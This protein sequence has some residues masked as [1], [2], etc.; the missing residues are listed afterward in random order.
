MIKSSIRARLIFLCAVLLCLLVTSTAYLTRE[1]SNLLEIE[2]QQVELIA[3]VKTANETHRTF[4]DLKY[5]LSDHAVSLLMRSENAAHAANAA[6]DFELDKLEMYNPE[7]VSLVRAELDEVV[8]LSFQAIDAYADDERVLG[9]S[10]MAKA[11]VHISRVDQE[12]SGLVQQFD[13]RA[14]E[15]QMVIEAESNRVAVV[16]IIIVILGGAIGLAI[17][18]YIV[19]SIN[20]PLHSLVEAISAITHG[21]LNAGIPEPSDD[22]FGEMT[23]AL[24]LL[25]DGL[26]E[27]KRFD[28]ERAQSEA[29]LRESEERFEKAFN[30][31]PSMLAVISERSGEIIDVN[32]AWLTAL[33][34]DRTHMIG[35][36]AD[37]AE[38]WVDSDA[39]R[40]FAE[41][42]IRR[43]SIDRFEARW[44]TAGDTIGEFELSAETIELNGEPCAIV[45]AIDVTERNRVDRLKDEF[46]SMVSHELRTPLTSIKGSLDLLTAG[47]TG[48]HSDDSRRLIEI[49]K[50]NSDRLLLIV[51]DILDAQKIQS[52]TMDYLLQ[53]LDLL[54]ALKSS[55]AVNQALGNSNNT[56]FELIDGLP[57]VKVNADPQK[58][59]QVLANLLSNAAKF[60][61]NGNTIEVFASRKNG[62]IRT[63]VQDYGPGIPPEFRDRVFDKFSQADGSNSRAASGTGLGLN[64]AKMIVEG[65]GGDIGFESRSGEGCAFY[66]DLPEVT[67]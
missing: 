25:R 42:L 29:K 55:I 32:D 57:G 14:A 17:T 50:N 58:F 24:S 66:F 44:L 65:M 34:W 67:D 18:V 31:S 63:T 28:N 5:W 41:A 61:P 4:G 10:L 2:T 56:P 16:S 38:M 59:Q 64:I 35:H 27:R 30:R 15:I 12:L 48:D 26:I 47:V 33:G 22:E 54:P 20:R 45:A 6:L 53:P 3:V 46:V 1:I 9:N 49:A 19:R 60:S 36:A 43:Q 8:K 13:A 11:R 7:L 51:N 52:G 62:M 23:Q 39:S 21:N 40:A 37:E